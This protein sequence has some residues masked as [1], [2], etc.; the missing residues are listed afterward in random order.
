MKFDGKVTIN[1]SKDVVWNFLIDPDLVSQCAPGVDQVEIIEID[2]KFRTDVVIA[3]GA[4]K[5]SFAMDIEW[6]ELD[7]PNRAIMRARGQAPGSAAEVGATIRQ[8][9]NWFGKLTCK[10]W[11]GLPV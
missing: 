8:R 10:L 7:P 2:K 5:V 11:A 9:Q 3:L 6:I 4:V 1:A